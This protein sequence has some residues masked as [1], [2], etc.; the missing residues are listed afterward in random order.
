MALLGRGNPVVETE[1]LKDHAGFRQLWDDGQT[2]SETL[3]AAVQA[4]HGAT[5]P[6]T[7]LADAYL[8]ASRVGLHT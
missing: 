3:A 1:P 4:W 7:S 5:E 2:E 6:C 8:E